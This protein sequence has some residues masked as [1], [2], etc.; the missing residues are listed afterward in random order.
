MQLA[1]GFGLGVFTIL[2]LACGAAMYF[3]RGFE[4]EFGDLTKPQDIERH[5]FADHRFV[6]DNGTAK[7]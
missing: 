5:K 3:L 4:K 2:L 6:D 7:H 1:I